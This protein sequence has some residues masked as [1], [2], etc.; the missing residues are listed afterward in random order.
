MQAHQAK[1]PG[2]G[3]PDSKRGKK[4]DKETG[5]VRKKMLDYTTPELRA[6]FDIALQKFNDRLKQR[7][8]EPKGRFF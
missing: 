3:N 1:N 5:M 4:S 2:Q 8:M 6:S 7:D